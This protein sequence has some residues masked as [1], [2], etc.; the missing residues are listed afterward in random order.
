MNVY[1]VRA[2]SPFSRYIAFH[3][4]HSPLFKRGEHLDRT[5]EECCIEIGS[6][7]YQREVD[8]DFFTRETECYMNI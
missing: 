7:L 8:P 3:G 2:N 5:F 4:I 1:A 6:S